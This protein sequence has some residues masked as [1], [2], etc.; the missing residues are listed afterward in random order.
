MKITTYTRI[1]LWLTSLTALTACGG[2]DGGGGSPS[3]SNGSSSAQTLAIGDL[4]VAYDNALQSTYRV[5]VDVLLVRLMGI[6]A[7]ISICDNNEAQG[8][9]AKVDYDHCLVKAPLEDG[10]ARFE[11]TAANHCDS[12]I[13]IIWPL[14]ENST[15]ITFSYQHSA[16]RSGTWLIQ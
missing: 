8:D 6:P 10:T 12:L 7:Y 9:I 5:D 11:L 14:E 13:A 2:G 16:E 1:W 4:D 3:N 15:P